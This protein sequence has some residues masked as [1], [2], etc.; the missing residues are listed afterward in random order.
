MATLI[1]VLVFCQALGAF[2]GAFAALWGE[3][4]YVLAIRDGKIDSAERAH[5]RV[6]GNGLRFGM[7]LLLLSS[8]ALVVISYL[9]HGEVQP[10]MTA[11]YW[12]FMTF[13][14]L[15]II[16]SWALARRNIPFALGSASAL[17]AWW[18][19][20]YLTLGQ[21]P[22]SYGAAAALYVVLTAVLYGVFHYLRILAQKI[23]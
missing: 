9:L 14:V 20:A 16:I 5:L 4:V 10:A 21:L 2:A 23:K 22:V 3:I 12:I 19:L 15:I 7:M 17:A 11:S 18:L 1:L 6:I 8:L 13:A